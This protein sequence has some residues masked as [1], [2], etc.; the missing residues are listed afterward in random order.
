M[1][2]GRKPKPTACKI[3]QGTFR[4]DRVPADMPDVDIDGMK[5]PSWLPREAVEHFGV[6]KSRVEALG[7]NSKTY[8]EVLAATALRLYQ[9]EVLTKDIQENGHNYWTKSRVEEDIKKANPSVAQLSDALRHVQSLLSEFGLSPAA[10][11]KVGGGKQE[12]KSSFAEF[13]NG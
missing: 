13:V 1:A 12:K 6:L 2:K 8:T 9:I 3:I 10:I 7:F 4:K 11:Q 5:A